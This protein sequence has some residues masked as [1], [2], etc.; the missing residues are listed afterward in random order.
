MYFAFT[1]FVSFISCRLRVIVDILSSSEQ[2][3]AGQLQPL[4]KQSG[5]LQTAPDSPPSCPRGGSKVD[6]RF[7]ARS[8]ACTCSCA[9]DCDCECVWL[10]VCSHDLQVGDRFWGTRFGHT[11]SGTRF[12]AQ[13]LGHMFTGTGLR[14]QVYG[15]RAWAKFPPSV[16]L[17]PF[18]PSVSLGSLC[19][20]PSIRFPPSIS[21]P[22]FPSPPF[23][24]PRFPPS[25]SL[26]PFPSLCQYVSLP[27]SVWRFP[28]SLLA[29]RETEMD[30]DRDRDRDRDIAESRAQ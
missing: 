1:L 27:L 22:P 4:G 14:A 21:L 3:R 28:P 6:S 10:C 15:H 19:F 24:S 7:P 11:F 12:R 13:V 5:S 2:A 9:C 25:V 18:P 16:F 23:P 8:V 30:K 20:P 26:P 17:P 29:K